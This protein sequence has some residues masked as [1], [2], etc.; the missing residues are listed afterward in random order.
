MLCYFATIKNIKRRKTKGKE[1]I[2]KER[3]KKKGR[4]SIQ[5]LF[6]IVL[7]RANVARIG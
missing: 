6:P 5:R 3:K 7:R 4:T 1:V 2:F